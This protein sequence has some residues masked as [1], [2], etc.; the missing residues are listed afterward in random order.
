[1]VYSA[2][3]NMQKCIKDIS[4]ICRMLMEAITFELDVLDEKKICACL[5]KMNDAHCLNQLKDMS[6]LISDAAINERSCLYEKN[7]G[8]IYLLVGS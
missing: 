2:E 5:P 3:F 7:P 1:M 4:L 6:I 8:E